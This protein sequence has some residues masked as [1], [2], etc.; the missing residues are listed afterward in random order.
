[1]RFKKKMRGF[2]LIEVLLVVGF[3]A[4][5]SIGVYITYNKV[6][7]GNAANTESRNIDTIRAGIKNIYGGSTNYKDLSN[8]V[9]LQARIVPDNMRTADSNTAI[10]NSFG[11]AVVIAT[12]RFPGAGA[13][14]NAFTITY[15][16]VPIDVCAK[17]A[18]GAGAGFNLVTVN[19]TVV[20]DTS[21]TTGN[22][23]DVAATAGACSLDAGNVLIFTSI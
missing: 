23:L 17:L 19:G 14:N 8:Q 11:G 1:M 13:E 20:K 9:A 3:I 21:K 16:G 5:A 2:T 15:D 18:T 7:S 6:Q 10:T 22:A 12:T 4:L